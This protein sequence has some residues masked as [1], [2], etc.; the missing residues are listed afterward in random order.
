M[1]A[2]SLIFL[3][4]S[5]KAEGGERFLQGTHLICR[6][7]LECWAK[8]QLLVKAQAQVAQQVGNEGHASICNLLDES[9][10]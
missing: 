6:E 9:N 8:I 7:L 2:R 3:T 10:R 4:C 1:T 5:A